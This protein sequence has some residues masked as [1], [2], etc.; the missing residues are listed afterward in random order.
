MPARYK[1]RR[2]YRRRTFRRRAPRRGMRKRSRR[3]GRKNYKQRLSYSNFGATTKDRARVKSKTNWAL[4]LSAAGGT[5]TWTAIS[6]NSFDVPQPVIGPQFPAAFRFYAAGYRCY[7]IHGSKIVVKLY[8]AE[9]GNGLSAVLIPAVN[10]T[11]LFG[12]TD[13][14]IHLAENKDAVFRLSGN[15]NSGRPI[16]VLKNYRGVAKVLNVSRDQYS[17]NDGYR[18]TMYYSDGLIQLGSPQTQAYWHVGVRPATSDASIRV[19]AYFQMT[20]YVE[21]SQDRIYSQTG[22]PYQENPEDFV[23]EE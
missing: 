2:T 4:D 19:I 9:A 10:V 11:T 1:R 14:P 21:L 22:F 17:S 15:T 12:P 13:Q 18:G 6:M 16:A 20:Q 23:E 7:K 5:T 8:N 3:T